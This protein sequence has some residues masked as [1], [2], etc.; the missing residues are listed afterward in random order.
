HGRAR[1]LAGLAAGTG[2][3]AHFSL[4]TAARTAAAVPA[5][6]ALGAAPEANAGPAAHQLRMGGG[7]MIAFDEGAHRRLPIAREYEPLPPAVAHLVQL[8][9][10]EHWRHG[11]EIVEQRLAL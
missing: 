8:E 6:P 4:L 1:I 9:R 3:S 5:V 2:K 10:V 11:R 7:D